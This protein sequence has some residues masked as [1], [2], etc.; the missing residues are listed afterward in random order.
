MGE[1]NLSAVQEIF[2]KFDTPQAFPVFGRA[3]T[4]VP[5]ADRPDLLSSVTQ[6]NSTNKLPRVRCC[7]RRAGVPAAGYVFGFWNDN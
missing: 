7:R 5:D 2:R 6:K 1:E 4:I 3:G